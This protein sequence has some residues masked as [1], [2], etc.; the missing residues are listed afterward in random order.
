MSTAK[1]G[2]WQN[3]CTALASPKWGNEIKQNELIS[4]QQLCRPFVD[5]LLSLLHC[6][7]GSFPCPSPLCGLNEANLSTLILLAFL[8]P[9]WTESMSCLHTNSSAVL[10][11]PLKAMHLSM[12]PFVSCENRGW[13]IGGKAWFLGNQNEIGDGVGPSS[14]LTW[15]QGRRK[16]TVGVAASVHQRNACRWAPSILPR[17]R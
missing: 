7:L 14:K 17:G 2:M 12:G 16:A 8:V 11:G 6:H 15:Y 13:Y 10:N 4:C 3:N 9:W 5:L 1:P